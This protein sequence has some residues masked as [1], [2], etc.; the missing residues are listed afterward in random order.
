MNLP[1]CVLWLSLRDLYQEHT[2]YQH[3]TLTNNA[4]FTNN[5][6]LLYTTHICCYTA[7]GGAESKGDRRISFC[8]VPA[9]CWGSQQSSSVCVVCVC[10]CVCVCCVCVCCVCVCVCACVYV[11]VRV[12][13]YICTNMYTDGFFKTDEY[14]PKRDLEKNLTYL[15][16]K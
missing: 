8:L 10:V 7:R 2:L 11:C 5:T 6:H 4:H 3:H 16:Y 1:E 12:C 14:L 15:T 13:A 9:R